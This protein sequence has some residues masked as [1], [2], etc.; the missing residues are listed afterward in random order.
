MKLEQIVTVLKQASPTMT[1]PK[2]FFQLMEL[3]YGDKLVI[4]FDFENK[5]M[6][7]RKEEN[8]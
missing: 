8:V 7:V 3:N 6:V 2:V 4:S 5:C 1:I